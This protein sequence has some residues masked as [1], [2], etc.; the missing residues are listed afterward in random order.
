MLTFPEISW[1]YFPI[2]LFETFEMM[3]ATIF[4]SLYLLDPKDLYT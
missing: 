1:A 3:Q 4:F 2:K